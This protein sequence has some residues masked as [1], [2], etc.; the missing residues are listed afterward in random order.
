MHEVSKLSNHLL[1]LTPK[2]FWGRHVESGYW[3]L[4]VRQEMQGPVH[5][6]CSVHRATRAD[7]GQGFAQLPLGQELT[8]IL[9]LLWQGQKTQAHRACW[10]PLLSH[11]KRAAGPL[12]AE[13]ED[14]S[15]KGAKKDGEESPEKLCTK[16]STS[17]LVSTPPPSPQLHCFLKCYWC[18]TKSWGREGMGQKG[19]VKKKPWQRGRGKNQMG[20]SVSICYYP[21]TVKWSFWRRTENIFV[22]QGKTAVRFPLKAAQEKSNSIWVKNGAA[23]SVRFSTGQMVKQQKLPKSHSVWCVESWDFS[24]KR[25]IIPFWLEAI[26]APPCPSILLICLFGNFNIVFKSRFNFGLQSISKII[27]TLNVTKFL[28]YS[29]LQANMKTSRAGRTPILLFAEI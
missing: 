1:P 17:S 19:S 3:E 23:P 10:P 2:K 9:T 16:R 26:K 11:S 8:F 14:G 24:S 6:C 18:A 27:C 15:Q 20:T 13:R 4:G 29:Q 25:Y 12:C 7:L 22:W 5:W 28:I 21:T